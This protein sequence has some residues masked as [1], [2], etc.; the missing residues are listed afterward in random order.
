MAD[1]KEAT[2]IEP[3][4]E[5]PK[6][7]VKATAKKAEPTYTLASLGNRS[8]EVLGISYV[9]FVGATAGLDSDKRYTISEAKKLIADW[10]TKGVK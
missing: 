4:A 10:Q 6:K 9:T 8:R 7:A 2:P 3:V 1:N 5:E